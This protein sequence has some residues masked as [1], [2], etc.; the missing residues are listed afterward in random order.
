MHTRNVLVH[1]T[2]IKIPAIVSISENFSQKPESEHPSN[3]EKFQ[4]YLS[5]LIHTYGIESIFRILEGNGL[6]RNSESF[7]SIGQSVLDKV[8]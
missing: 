4:K 1:T 3:W 6:N 7:T 5:D 8:H 2:C